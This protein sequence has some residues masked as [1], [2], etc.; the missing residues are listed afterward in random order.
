MKYKYLLLILLLP[1]VSALQYDLNLLYEE[2]EL[3]L[4]DGIQKIIDWGLNVH[5]DHQLIT[6]LCRVAPTRAARQAMNLDAEQLSHCNRFCRSRAL[7]GT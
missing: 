6:T 3:Q 1:L 2:G 4:T 7:V 5:V